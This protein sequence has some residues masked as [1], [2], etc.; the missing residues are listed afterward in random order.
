MNKRQREVIR[1]NLRRERWIIAELKRTYLKALDDINAEISRLMARTD[2]QNLQSIIY[3]VQ[4]Q[5]AL[6]DQINGFLDVLHRGNFELISQYLAECY[7]NGWIGNLYDLQGQGIPLLFRI[8]QEQVVKAIQTDSKLSKNLYDS[9]GLDIKALKKSVR[10]ELSRGISQ[11]LSY[12]QIAINLKRI[13]NISYNNAVK[14]ARTEGHRIS[15]EATFNCQMEAKKNGCKILKRWDSTLD[16]RTRGTHQL[17]DG[18]T[19]DVDEPYVLI[20]NGVEYKAMYPSNFG[21]AG[22]DINCRCVSLQVAEW[23]LDDE[24]FSKYDGDKREIKDF[25]NI[26]EYEKFKAEFWNWEGEVSDN[27]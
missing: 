16:K 21:V 4:Y 1:L 19:V 12:N 23:L 26:N 10:E 7:E 3:Q 25:K 9:L 27:R 20:K 6:K 8:D 5:K 18:Q 22:E 15:E 17:L 13:A 11:S 2:L 14:I 24:S